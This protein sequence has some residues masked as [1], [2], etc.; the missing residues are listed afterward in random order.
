MA[1]ANDGCTKTVTNKT[2]TTAGLRFERTIFGVSNL[3][4]RTQERHFTQP[5]SQP[6]SQLALLG[7]ASCFR[8]C[9]FLCVSVRDFHLNW[10]LMPVLLPNSARAPRYARIA[11][12]EGI[13]GVFSPALRSTSLG[14]RRNPTRQRHA[15]VGFRT[16]D[17][18]REAYPRTWGH[19]LGLVKG[20]F[21]R[22]MFRPLTRSW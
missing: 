4:Q 5:A 6:A 12:A 14:Q 13:V 9:A 3:V 10:L 2:Q 15:G 16:E 11:C 8:G 1:E 20:E 19:R 21:C 22:R 17:T 18:G 7:P